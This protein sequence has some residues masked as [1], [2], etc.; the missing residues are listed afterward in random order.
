[1]Y[2]SWSAGLAGLVF[3]RR[4]PITLAVTTI[5]AA[6]S[7]LVAG[8]S[9]MSPE[10]TNLVPVLKSYWL[11]IHVAVITSSYGFLGLGALLALVNL[12]LISVRSKHNVLRIQYTI[13]ELAYITEIT[14]II[15]L[16]LLTIGSF[17]GGVWANESWGRYWGWDPKETWAMVTIL[18]YAFITHMHKIKGLK[19]EFAFN[20]AALLGF[21][22]VLMTFFGVNYY[23]TG[24]HS[25]AQGDPPPVPTSVFIALA[26]I[27]ALLIIAWIKE[28]QWR[29]STKDSEVSEDMGL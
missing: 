4:S 5:L 29:K 3:A 10:L 15:G 23:L 2:I 7:L 18:I 19:G 12:V 26:L 9:W 28:N 22:S 17:L 20:T 27:T 24:L 8:M 16:Y 25:Y 14:L 6:I 21:G 11:I 13:K 1:M